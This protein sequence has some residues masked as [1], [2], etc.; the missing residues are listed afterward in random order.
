MAARRVIPEE[1][2]KRVL[3][4]LR[5][6]DRPTLIGQVAIEMGWSLSEA[7]QALQELV[8]AGLARPVTDAELRTYDILNG[9][10]PVYDP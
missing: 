6:S 5:K 7:E 1:S 10:L 4:R 2:R 9:F 3:E 8:N